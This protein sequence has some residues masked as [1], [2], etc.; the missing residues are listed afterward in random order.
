MQI[1]REC[2]K[3][4]FKERFYGDSDDIQDEFDHCMDLSKLKRV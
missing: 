2:V 3:K 4:K 1:K